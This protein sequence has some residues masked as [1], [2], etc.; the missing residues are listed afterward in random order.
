MVQLPSCSPWNASC[1]G[2]VLMAATLSNLCWR[3]SLV[4]VKQV[5]EQAMRDDGWGSV[6]NRI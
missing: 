6:R 5:K 1:S 4:E 3:L 2:A